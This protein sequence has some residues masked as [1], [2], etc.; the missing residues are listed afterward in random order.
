MD[1]DFLPYS[2]LHVSNITS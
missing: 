1:E 2:L